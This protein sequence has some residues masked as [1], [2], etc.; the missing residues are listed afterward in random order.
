MLHHPAVYIL[1]AN[2]MLIMVAKYDKIFKTIAVTYPVLALIALLSTQG[3]HS[4]EILGIEFSFDSKENHKVMGCAFLITSLAVN[5]YAASQNKKLEIIVGGFYLGFSIICLL[6]S[7]YISMFISLELMLI[8]ASILIFVGENK[9]S[10][11]A[12]KQY[13]LTHVFSGSLILTGICYFIN[14]TGSFEITNLTDFFYISKESAFM[15]G[16]VLTGCL[17]NAAAFPFSSWMINCY[18]EATSKGFL[19]L[20]T[21]TIKVSIILI[22]KLFSG[23]EILKYFGVVM[24]LYGIT[25]ACFENDLRRLFCYLAISQMGFILTAISTGNESVIQG[26][27]LFMAV[28]IIYKLILGLYS[29]IINDY[30]HIKTCDGLATLNLPVLNF[31]FGIGFL[32]LVNFPLSASFMSKISVSTQMNNVNLSYVQQ[33]LN[34]MTFLSLPVRQI[35]QTKN[36]K[37]INI[38]L[39]GLIALLIPIIMLIIFN[40]YQIYYLVGSETYNSDI[41]LSTNISKQLFIVIIGTILA[42]YVKFPRT[43]TR[44]FSIDLLVF[45]SNYC[46]YLLNSYKRLSKVPKQDF[47]VN[48]VEG[49][50]IKHL[51]KIHNQSLAL[52]VIFLMLTGLIL[53]QIN[54]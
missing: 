10:V 38:N 39:R 6:A 35:F 47:S 50:I 27:I 23:F 14:K 19:Y 54:G 4:F 32:F 9:D 45:V 13:F 28:H 15:A 43:D 7:D 34:I 3:A 53:I 22:V 25:Y 37:N 31:A 30:L 11:I 51:S 36:N 17:I 48:Q 33:F 52:G 1:I 16:L 5:I 18:A 41:I 2:I 44:K 42:F 12:T 8:A 49:S 46:N 24:M 20:S 21:F 40:I 29:A 26:A